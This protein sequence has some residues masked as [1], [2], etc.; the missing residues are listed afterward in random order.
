MLSY[1]KIRQCLIKGI[2]YHHAGLL[3]NLKE[4][5]E[6]LFEKGLISVLYATETFAVGINMPA[7]TVCFDSLEKYD[8]F[9]FR[10][11]NSK[12]YFQIAGRAGRRGIDTQGYVIALVDR[13]RTDVNKV[14]LITSKDVEPI[15]SQFKLSFNTV[16]NLVKN[17]NEQETEIILKSNFDYFLRTKSETK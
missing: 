9:T 12:E 11:L 17:H 15:I 4:I 5:V 6:R 7:K 10:Y 14:K 2:G 8:G 3:P 13:I 16:L 1:Q